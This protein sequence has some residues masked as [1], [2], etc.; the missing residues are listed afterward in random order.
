MNENTFQFAWFQRSDAGFDPLPLA[1]SLW[2]DDQM[3]GVA[4]SGLLARAL[5]Q[6]MADAGRTG[7]VPARYHVDLFRPAR[8]ITTTAS[9]RVVREGPRLVLLDAV[10]EQEGEVV[11]RAG[12]TFLATSAN[13]PGEIWSAPGERPVPP[14]DGLLPARGE[15]HVPMFA[16]A[17]GWS[18]N[19]AD[20][21]N[22]GRHQT[23]QTAIPI[24]YGEECSPFQAV[25]SIAD[26]TSMV[27]NWG[28]HGVEHINTD[29]DLA[30]CRLPD[31]CRL[32]LRATDH[33]AADGIAVG[34]AEVFDSS[35]TLGTATVTSLVNT[36]RT[37]D[38]SG[39]VEPRGAV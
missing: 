30:L 12:A 11:A 38:L 23:W 5:E 34:T 32:G 9:A 1:Q 19:F 33:V 20:H 8:M 16:S 26:A 25:A 29:I 3:H 39:G 10:V 6:A 7:L 22:P 24:V 4:V 36:R 18:D 21:Q 28:G 14:P 37:V 17:A 15:H 13:A 31:S 2:R 35:G 27:T